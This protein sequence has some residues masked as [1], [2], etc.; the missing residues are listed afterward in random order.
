MEI[1]YTAK[2]SRCKQYRYYLSR[3]WDERLPVLTYIGLN[4]SKA[5]AKK[6][7]PTIRRCM[8]FAQRFGFGG[9]EVLNLF[10]YRATDPKELFLSID[11]IGKRNNQFLR[12]YI[13]KAHQVV[14]IWGNHGVHLDR[15]LEV[16]KMVDQPFCLAINKSGQ[17]AHPLYLSKQLELQ[18]YIN[19]K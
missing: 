15:Y 10:A 16:L 18:A 14:L 1:K 13:K 11:P 8:D 5:D 2:L 6:D 19:S 4:P 3:Q 17:P 12:Q 7:D 9:I